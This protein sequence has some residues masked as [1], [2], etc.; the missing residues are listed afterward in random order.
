MYVFVT[1]Q[2]KQ[3]DKTAH[4]VNRKKTTISRE[5]INKTFIYKHR[6]QYMLLGSFYMIVKMWHAS[7]GNKSCRGQYVY[8][9]Y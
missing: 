9:S 5:P 2:T 6:K 3:C 8:A 4:S 7:G 1:L